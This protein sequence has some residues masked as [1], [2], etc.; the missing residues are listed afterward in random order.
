MKYVLVDVKAEK[1]AK[2]LVFPSNTGKAVLN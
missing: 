2:L 1:E